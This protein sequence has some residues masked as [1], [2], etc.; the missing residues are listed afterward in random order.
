LT[1]DDVLA[2]VN[3]MAL[4]SKAVVLVMSGVGGSVLIVVGVGVGLES[5][6][7]DSTRPLLLF[8]AA[9]LSL[10]GA[11]L[12]QFSVWICASGFARAKVR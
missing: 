9:G 3:S 5:L 6:G 2:D 4:A 10:F 8:V 1:S 12:V 11:G 7:S